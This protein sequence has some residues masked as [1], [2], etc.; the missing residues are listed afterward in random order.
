MAYTITPKPGDKWLCANPCQHKDCV[1]HRK[2]IAALCTFC[3]KPIGAGVSMAFH[4]L[5]GA[6]AHWGC[7]MAQYAPTKNQ[8]A[9]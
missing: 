1:E 7:I 4:S 5:D 2:T 9:R 8:E 6:P 3:N